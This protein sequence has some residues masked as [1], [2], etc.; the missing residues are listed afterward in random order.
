MKQSTI[1]GILR[2]QTIDIRDAPEDVPFDVVAQAK[3]AFSRRAQDRVAELV[4]DSLIDEDAPGQH[5]HL[6]FEHPRMWIEVSIS[7]LSAWANLHGVMYPAIPGRVELQ[8]EQA[9]TPIEAEVTHS[10]FRIGRSP[11]GLVRLHLGESVGSG[12]YT[13]WFCI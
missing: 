11:R 12:V 10:A 1:Q 3:A 4:W 9:S 5:H 13:D 2:G 7:V 8:F 6:R